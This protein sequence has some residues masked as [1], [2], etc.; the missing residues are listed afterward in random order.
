MISRQLRGGDWLRH[1]LLDVWKGC[2][3]I[4]IFSENTPHKNLQRSLPYDRWRKWSSK[5]LTETNTSRNCSLYIFIVNTV[6][7]HVGRERCCTCLLPVEYR[8][9]SNS[10]PATHFYNCLCFLLYDVKSNSPFAVYPQ[11][12]PNDKAFYCGAGERL[13]A[14]FL[15]HVAS[16]Q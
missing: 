7:R 2:G 8:L 4:I 9:I 3:K 12:W 13:S 16:I 14:A 15:R 1:R 10:S 11:S 5:K 6:Y